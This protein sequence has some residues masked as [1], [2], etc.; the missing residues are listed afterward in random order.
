MRAEGVLALFDIDGTLIRAGDPAHRLA[1]DHALVTVY[2]VPATLD[3]LSLAGMLDR[4]IARL[5][6]RPFDIEPGAIDAGLPELVRVMGDHYRTLVGPGERHDHL[7]PGLP[8]AAC[9]LAEAGVALAVVTGSA[10]PVARAKLEAAGLARLFPIGAYGDQADHRGELVR[11]G[12]TQAQ[13]HFARPFDAARAVVVGDTPK[14]IAAAR[15]AG[16]RVLAVATGVV[17]RDALAAAAPDTLL[18]DLSEI[19]AVMGAI[20]G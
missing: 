10:A 8:D 13:R 14:D 7:L 9:A 19:A 1:F 18:D 4:Q 6:L 20:L 3:G 11:L 2:G 16:T 5:A 15:D 17:S 12:L